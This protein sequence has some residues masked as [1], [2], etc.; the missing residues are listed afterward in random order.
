MSFSARWTSTGVTP[1]TL[2]SLIGP[3]P[4][5][6]GTVVVVAT[7][8]VGLVA[9]TF[10][11]GVAFG[12]ELAHAPATST[13]ARAASA[14]LAMRI[15]FRRV[16]GVTGVLIAVASVRQPRPASL[17]RSGLAVGPGRHQRSSSLS[18]SASEVWVKSS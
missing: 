17:R 3:T 1:V 14:P 7:F 4:G 11:F 15:W 12:E 8:V 13:N 2:T 18:T 9:L 5:T 16:A 10:A 6:V